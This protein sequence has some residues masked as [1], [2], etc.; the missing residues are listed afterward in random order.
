MRELL[1]R[2]GKKALRRLEAE[3]GPAF[4]VEA[5][6]RR[7]RVSVAAVERMDTRSELIGI[8]RGGV[9]Q[10]PT[11]QFKRGKVCR[12]VQP[13]ATALGPSGALHF[14]TVPRQSL[15]MNGS[16]QSLLSFVLSGD[17]DAE[18]KIDYHLL[19]LMAE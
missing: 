12:W 1:V 13:V 2:R 18:V 9:R 15:G 6:A 14:L 11:W 3:C 16:A 10:Y 5:V 19:R 8:T 4:T 17:A 7:L